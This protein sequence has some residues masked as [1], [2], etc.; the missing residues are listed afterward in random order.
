MQYGT[1]RPRA[2]LRRTLKIKRK[3]YEGHKRLPG[4]HI[5]KIRVSPTQYTIRDRVAQIPFRTTTERRRFYG[6]EH[7]MDAV[8]SKLGYS[9]AIDIPDSR[10]DEFVRMLVRAYGE[11]GV[12]GMIQSQINV[13]KNPTDHSERTQR[14]KFQRMHDSLEKQFGGNGWAN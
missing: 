10:R 12:H 6:K 5:E 3:G 4:G 13:R 9:R 1:R 11:Q 2:K 8:A 7:P 14:A